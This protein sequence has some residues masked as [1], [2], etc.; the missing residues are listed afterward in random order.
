[1]IYLFIFNSFLNKLINEDLREVFDVYFQLR[2][3][4]Y[5]VTD[6]PEEVRFVQRRCLTVDQLM[7]Q[8]SHQRVVTFVKHKIN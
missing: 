4:P 3:D 8:R 1:M 2:C 6:Q 5:E 7:V